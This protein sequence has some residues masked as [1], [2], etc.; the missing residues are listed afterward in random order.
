MRYRSLFSLAGGFLTLPACFALPNGGW[1]HKE[2]SAAY[3]QCGGVD[4]HG[5]TCCPKDFACAKS[6]EWYSQCRP[7]DSKGCTFQAYDQCGGIGF[8]GEGCCMSG[9]SCVKLSEWWSQCDPVSASYSTSTLKHTSSTTSTTKHSTSTSKHSTSDPCMPTPTTSSC[10]CSC[11]SSSSSSSTTTSPPTST[12][13]STTATTSSST[14]TTSS[15]TRLPTVTSKPSELR[16]SPTWNISDVPRIREHYWTIS[17]ATGAPDGFER[18]MLVVNDQ[19]PGPLIEANEGD[20]IVVHVQNLLPQPV[21]IHWHGLAQN[22]SNWQGG[23]S[24]VTQC[25]I[26]VLETYTYTFT[27]FRPNPEGQFGSYWWHAHRRALYAD[28]ITGPLIIHSKNDPLKRGE[29]Y[30][31]DQIITIH[32]WYHTDSTTITD[33]LETTAGFNGSFVAPS[34]QTGLING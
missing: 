6:S 15:A 10:S 9:T 19:F 16:L 8:A 3:D 33:A 26:G 23:P 12:T 13:S 4:W 34:P 7:A 11:C 29:D 1:P 22:G 31:I 5:G 17:E 21:T 14:I 27:V 28:G 20:T 25:P 30:D 2:C 32:D 24:G 18:T